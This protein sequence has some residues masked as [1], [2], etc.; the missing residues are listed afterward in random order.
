MHFVTQSGNVTFLKVGPHLLNFFHYP[1]PYIDNPGENV[2]WLPQ[3]VQRQAWV[4]H[5]ACIGVDYLNRDSDVELAYCVLTKLVSEMISEKC[6]GVYI[7]QDNVLAPNDG[8]LYA[9]L[10]RMASSRELGV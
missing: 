5:R 3:A 4:E 9:E 1:K 2:D 6:T 8:S 10:K 7:P